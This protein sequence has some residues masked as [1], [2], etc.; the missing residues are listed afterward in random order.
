MSDS[1]DFGDVTTSFD[2]LNP[3]DASAV[4]VPQVNVDTS[5]LQ[6]SSPPD[7]T[8]NFQGLNPP[9][10][11]QPQIPQYNLDTSGLQVPTAPSSPETSQPGFFD[12]LGGSVTDWLSQPSNLLKLGLGAG[13]LGLG[14]ASSRA[15]QSQGAKAQ[16]QIAGIPQN[17]QQLSQATQQQ[18][19]DLATKYQAMVNN[20]SSAIQGMAQPIMQQYTAL[21][22]T[23]NQGQLTPANKQ[24][25]D[26]ARARVAQQAA[27]RGG[28]GAEQAQAQ[29][30]RLQNTL[31][32]SQM[33]QA[34]QMYSAAS[35]AAVTAQQTQLTGT[36][37]AN[38][39]LQQ[40][41]QTALS[42]T[43]LQD[44]YALNAIQTGLQNDRAAR[45]SMSNFYTQLAAV[46]AGLPGTKTTATATP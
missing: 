22:N 44:Q 29:L 2:G 32:A 14:L 42:T 28:V 19:Q 11:S 20:A 3:P 7:V 34:L 1:F 39:Y 35:P 26:A 24:I 8:T 17:L 25:L 13:G 31:L 4:D 9:D 18:L 21:I 5:G 40:G 16:Q 10:V 6:P 30:D 41:M 36:N 38:Q 45:Q 15:A 33:Q 27:G 12:K 46:L 37:A 43:G 23:T